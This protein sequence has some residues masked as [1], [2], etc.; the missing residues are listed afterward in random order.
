MKVIR[1]LDRN[2]E[3][4]CM[5]VLL[6]LIACIM[7][8]QVIMRY[9]FKAS[10]PWPEECCR[11]LWVATTCF[12][13]GYV[14]QKDNALKVEIVM[15]MLPEK[16]KMVVEM[17][18]RILMMLLHGYMVYH[19]FLSMAALRASG[20]LSPAMKMPVW[21]LYLVLG[22]GFALGAVRYLEQVVRGVRKGKTIC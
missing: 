4:C 2:L 18:I 14:V 9:L 17:G 21:I 19:T 12:S 10:M 8:A 16:G 20:Q 22:I 3:E 1:W 6:V 7:M 11:Y 5:A 13:L 15:G